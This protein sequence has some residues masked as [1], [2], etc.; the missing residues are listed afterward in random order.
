MPGTEPEDGHLPDRGRSHRAV[1]DFQEE[2][3]LRMCG[4]F[5][6][7]GTLPPVTLPRDDIPF[8]PFSHGDIYSSMMVRRNPSPHLIQVNST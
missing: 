3:H 5:A 2:P 4:G 8:L 6:G 7:G 1:R